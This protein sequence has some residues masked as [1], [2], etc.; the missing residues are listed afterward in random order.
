MVVGFC[1]DEGDLFLEEAAI[2]W[3]G[4]TKTKPLE[5]TLPKHL[6][7]VVISDAPYVYTFEVDNASKCSTFKIL[8]IDDVN[9][10]SE[11]PLTH[12]VICEINRF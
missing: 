4:G 1:N 11:L 3:P 2:I 5:I 9:V 10:V 7:A 12:P 6:R 8:Q